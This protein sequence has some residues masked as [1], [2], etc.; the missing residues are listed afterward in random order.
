MLYVPYEYIYTEND[1]T[2]LG[3]GGEGENLCAAPV[4]SRQEC[5]RQSAHAR[6][7]VRVLCAHG[8]DRGGG[9]AGDSAFVLN[10]VGA[11]NTVSDIRIG[12]A[13][14]VRTESG[15]PACVNDDEMTI[16]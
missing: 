14:R 15:W 6:S 4:P 10:R 7:C 8:G 3:T 1:H 13:D 2:L 16:I 5:D 12:F 9:A 11:Y